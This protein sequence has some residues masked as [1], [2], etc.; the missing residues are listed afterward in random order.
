MNEETN[1]TE[2]PQ[3]PDSI[4]LSDLHL[5]SQIV[6]LASSRGAFRGAE[7]TTVGGI[8]DKLTAFLSFVQQQQ[9]AAAAGGEQAEQPS[10]E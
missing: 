4:S 2:A 7:L 5:L 8:Y 1:Q 6:D 3:A 9:E 10:E